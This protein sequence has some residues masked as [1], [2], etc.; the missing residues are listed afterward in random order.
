MRRRG[1][2]SV[3]HSLKD[4]LTKAEIKFGGRFTYKRDSFVAK[5]KP[6]EMICRDHGKFLQTPKIHLKARHGCPEC[7]RLAGIEAHRKTKE[8]FVEQARAIHGD[9]YDYSKVDYKTNDTQVVITCNKHGDFTQYPSA[10]LSYSR[11]CRDC[12]VEE[13]GL[14]N[15]FNKTLESLSTT[16]MATLYHVKFHRHNGTCFQKVGVT[17][18]T[19]GERFSMVGKNKYEVEVVRL[20][21]NNLKTCVQMEELILQ[22]LRDADNL[23]KVKDFKGTK[24]G[25]WTECFT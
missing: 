8:S 17:R 12:L 4:F 14:G 20:C 22:S 16:E 6:M 11:G 9:K 19:V 10:H 5:H 13:G 25:G 1:E 21:H 7:G 15:P 18:K 23:Y 2:E 3:R 24:V